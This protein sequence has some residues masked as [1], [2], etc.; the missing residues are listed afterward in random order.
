MPSF[1][2]AVIS[3]DVVSYVQDLTYSPILVPEEGDASAEA[4]IKHEAPRPQTEPEE[5]ETSY[6]EMADER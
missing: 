2:F 3:D 4:V 6:R 1:L 5:Q